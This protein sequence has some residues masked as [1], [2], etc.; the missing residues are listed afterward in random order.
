MIPRCLCVCSFIFRNVVQFSLDACSIEW[1]C[2]A[3][4]C[5]HVFGPTALGLRDTE[6][7]VT[8][9][10]M[11]LANSNGD[12]PPSSDSESMDRSTGKVPALHCPTLRDDAQCLAML[13]RGHWISVPAIA[14]PLAMAGTM[15]PATTKR[16]HQEFKTVITYSC[17]SNSGT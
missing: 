14:G 7:P 13:R 2:L 15:P 8:C 3:V 17:R 1:P 16:C 12:M 6:H 10:C 11:S 4:S 9:H 5:A